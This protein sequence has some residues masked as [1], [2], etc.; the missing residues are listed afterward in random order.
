MRQG[1]ASLLHVKTGLSRAKLS[2][3][4]DAETWMNANK[5]VELGFADGILYEK[6]EPAA[7]ADEGYVFSRMAVTNSLLSKFPKHEPKKQG[8]P[9]E[10]LDKRL[11]LLLH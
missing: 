10:S 4:M 1:G 7:K 11:S 5:A 9:I 2:H 6:E 3:M 8:T